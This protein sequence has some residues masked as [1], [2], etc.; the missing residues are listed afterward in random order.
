MVSSAVSTQNLDEVRVPEGPPPVSPKRVSA[1]LRWVNLVAVVVP[2]AGLVTAA[3]VLWSHGFDAL[4]LG[5]FTG[6][7]LVSGFGITVGYH[8]L[9]TH[10]S[11]E[12]SR[13][14]KWAIGIAGS[15]AVEGP[16]RKWV[17]THRCHHQHSDTGRDPHSPHAVQDDPVGAEGHDDNHPTEVYG[18]LRGFWHAHVG[19]MI[20]PELPG[21]ARYVPDL[22]KDRDV[23]LLSRLFPVWVLV[24][25]LLPT[26]LGGLLTRPGGWSWS[27]ACIAF[28]WGGLARIFLVHHVTWSINS[29]CHIWGARPYRSHDESRNN[30][31]FGV[32]GMGEGWHNNH[33][34]FPTSARHG[35]AWWQLD[36]SYLI[37]RLLS[38]CGLAW[39]V[40]V[41]DAERLASKRI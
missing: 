15:M 2:F 28:F 18:L 31:V 35:L 30:V 32:L 22:I 25:L 13:T 41:P 17:A 3:V 11:F 9:F 16:I 1:K 4:Q 12:T 39:N 19:W 36:T 21:Y 24:S 34:A 5:I 33:H 8:R 10:R 23:Q 20:K 29:I 14:M 27:G 6:M 26:L 38:A 40:K 7:Y 37:I